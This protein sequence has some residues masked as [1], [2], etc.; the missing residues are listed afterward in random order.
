MVIRQSAD[1]SPTMRRI[2][3]SKFKT[4]EPLISRAVNYWEAEGLFWQPNSDGFLN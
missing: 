3:R 1:S 4:Y 2:R